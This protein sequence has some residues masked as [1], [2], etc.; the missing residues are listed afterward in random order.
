MN[1]F[2]QQTS[3][4]AADYPS[5]WKEYI[6][7]DAA[8]RVLMVA[9]KSAKMRKD[10]LQHTLIAHP[11]PGVGKTA[12]ALLIANEMGTNVRTVSGAVDKDKARIIFATMQDNDVLFWDEAHQMVDSGKKKAEWLLTYLQDGTIAGPLGMEVQPRVTIVAATTDA[13]KIPENIASR[14]TLRPPMG[15][16]LP[17]EATKIAQM[18]AAKVLEPLDLPRLAPADAALIATASR[19][20]PRAMRQL[21]L[22]L[23][24]LTITDELP[25]LRKGR[26]YDIPA[27]LERLDIQADGLTPEAVKYL[28]ILAREFGGTAGAKPLEDRLQ[29]SGGLDS[30]ER[31]LMDLGMV[32]KTRSGRT[33]TQAG[34]RRYLEL[35]AS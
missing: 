29:M 18:L 17:E 24:D 34:I 8:K 10:M 13:H 32:A 15:D 28:Q 5:T 19:G 1:M 20:N 30:I 26:A 9:A 3:I 2:I 25:L 6:G 27:L 33:I 35:E 22:N 31:V 23:R 16:Y 12:L 21:L 7:Q 11:T 4:N 14:F